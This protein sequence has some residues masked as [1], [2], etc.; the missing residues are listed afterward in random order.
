METILNA[1]KVLYDSLKKTIQ[2]A[3]DDAIARVAALE[4]RVNNKANRSEL[5][6]KADRGELNDFAPF[7]WVTQQISSAIGNVKNYMT[8]AN[9]RG[10]GS[11]AM[12]Q[13]AELYI[14][15][16][17]FIEGDDNRAIGVASHAEGIK[18]HAYGYGSHVEG[19]GTITYGQGSSVSG[20]YNLTGYEWFL[21]DEWDP[22]R[23]GTYS[24]GDAARVGYD[25][26]ICLQAVQSNENPS[27]SSSWCHIKDLSKSQSASAFS[28]ASNVLLAKYLQIVGNGMDMDFNSNAYTLDTRGNAWF[29]GKVYIGSTS[30]RYQDDGSKMVA[31]IPDWNQSDETST[32]YI[33]NRPFGLKSATKFVI[34]KEELESLTKT[35]ADEPPSIIAGYIDGTYLSVKQLKVTGQMGVYFNIA[36]RNP[37][38]VNGRHYKFHKNSGVTSLWT[39]DIIDG[40]FFK[41]AYNNLGPEEILCCVLDEVAS[42]TV[43]RTDAILADIDFIDPVFLPDGLATE[44]YVTNAI[45]NAD[46]GGGGGGTVDV[47]VLTNDEIDEIL[48]S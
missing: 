25:V 14:G 1:L 27:T 34:P 47:D 26:Y 32:D 38:V 10:T 12:N 21:V 35:G 13:P 2:A 3:H 6:N 42:R 23:I 28:G 44:E 18:S 46:I 9:P 20:V 5:A 7:W 43:F 39:T 17:A 8:K 37:I 48:A 24:R 45:A 40:V 22:N 36:Q 11:F 31:T 33:K 41:I 30:G 15:D 19:I 4:K 29:S 16:K